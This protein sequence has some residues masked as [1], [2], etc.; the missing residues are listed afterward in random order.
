MVVVV[1]A[2]GWQLRWHRLAHHTAAGGGCMHGCTTGSCWAA[3]RACRRAACEGSRHLM[4][5]VCHA[6]LLHQLVDVAL[7][8]LEAVLQLALRL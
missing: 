3:S 1:A 8:H 6:L 2:A 4:D 5:L 7:M